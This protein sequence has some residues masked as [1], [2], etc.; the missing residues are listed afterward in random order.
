MERER[1]SGRDRRGRF[2]K[3]GRNWPQSL[4][5]CKDS[6]SVAG[7][8]DCKDRLSGGGMKRARFPR[9][10]GSVCGTVLLMAFAANPNIVF[11]DSNPLANTLWRFQSYRVAGRSV[12]K[13]DQL[14]FYSTRGYKY[15]FV[16]FSESGFEEHL[17]CLGSEGS[18][19]L[20]NG[21]L[22]RSLPP[23]QLITP[24]ILCRDQE[25][26]DLFASRPRVRFSKDGRGLELS[27]GAA[28]LVLI[29]DESNVP[30]PVP[31]LGSTSG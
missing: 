24:A 9:R 15:R 23:G 8:L 16:K 14:E 30:T 25:L 3:R 10:I 11:A 5:R 28:R 29:R 12:P 17:G 26:S 31:R 22:T 1:S 27:R 20:V 21:H 7:W 19:A 18:Y 4:H 13:I 6:Q 2:A